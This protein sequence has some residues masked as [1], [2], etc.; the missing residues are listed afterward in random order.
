MSITLRDYLNS[1]PEEER[2]AA[3]KRGKELI[4]EFDSLSKDSEPT[5]NKEE[6]TTNIKLEKLLDN[7]C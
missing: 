1:L 6:S 4:D 2:V 5:E 3:E 7:F